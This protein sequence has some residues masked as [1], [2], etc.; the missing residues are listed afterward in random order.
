MESEELKK[1]HNDFIQ[2]LQKTIERLELARIEQEKTK[3][4]LIEKVATA[5]SENNIL[6]R[7]LKDEI[8]K[9]KLHNTTDLVLGVL[10]KLTVFVA[11]VALVYTV[12]VIQPSALKL[13]KDGI[14]M[15][16]ATSTKQ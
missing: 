10:G 1:Y 12:S 14:E 15:S 8:G 11:I 5:L 13:Q 4:A 16:G 2:N 6:K 3:D 9:L 7:E